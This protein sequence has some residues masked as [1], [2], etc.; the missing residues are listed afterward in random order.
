M[1]TLSKIAFNTTDILLLKTVGVRE[2]T[3]K[4]GSKKK[5]SGNICLYY[6]TNCLREYDLNFTFKMVS[7]AKGTQEK[8]T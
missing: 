2:K 4:T 1:R 7:V 3:D 6:L 5:F 8:L